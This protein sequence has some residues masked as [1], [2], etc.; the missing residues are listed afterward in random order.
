[1]ILKCICMSS[2]NYVFSIWYPLIQI[3]DGK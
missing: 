1:L 3:V 2:I